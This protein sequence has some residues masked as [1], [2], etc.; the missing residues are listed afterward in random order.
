M[1]RQEMLDQLYTDEL[2]TI[3]A[4]AIQGANVDLE[5]MLRG[6][7]V[8]EGLDNDTLEAVWDGRFD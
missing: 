3:V 4:L 5:N 7:E 2:N 8:F 1:K 6:Y